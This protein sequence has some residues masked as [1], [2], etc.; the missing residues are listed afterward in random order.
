VYTYLRQGPRLRLTTGRNR[1]ILGGGHA[2]RNT[3]VVVNAVNA[4][5]RPTTI[6]VV[7]IRAFDTWWRRFRRKASMTAVV[8]V[9]AP[10]NTVPHV[11]EP[12]HSFMGLALQ[13]SGLVTLSRE[14]LTYML[15]SHS[16]GKR[17]VLVRLSPLM[18]VC[19]G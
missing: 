12:G 5:N 6:Q 19:I 3:Y 7:G 18:T 8:H 11:L 13:T 16:M 1:Q 14:K 10:G 4:G 2:D 17:D 9:G 15:V